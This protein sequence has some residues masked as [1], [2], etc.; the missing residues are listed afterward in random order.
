MPSRLFTVLQSCVPVDGAS[1]Q[2]ALFS[3]RLWLV[4]GEADR[5][6]RVEGGVFASELSKH[7]FLF[8]FVLFSGM[9]RGLCFATR[10][11]KLVLYCSVLR[12]PFLLAVDGTEKHIA[13]PQRCI[14]LG[15]DKCGV[16][17]QLR[18]L[19]QHKEH[20]FGGENPAV[21][22]SAPLQCLIISC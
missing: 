14:F 16:V 10:P 18:V 4:V 13:V 21:P 20:P 22:R 2:S 15:K 6:P 11:A 17:L 7:T 1:W 5:E 12:S 9:K 19:W 8:Y 3:L